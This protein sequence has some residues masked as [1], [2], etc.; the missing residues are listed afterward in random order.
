[1]PEAQLKV[2]LLRYTADPEETVAMAAKLCYSSSDVESLKGKIAVKDQK[3]FVGK[4]IAMGHMSPLEHASFTFAIEGI[5]RACSHQLVRHRI[6]SYSQQSQRYVSE[7]A[8]FDYVI[9]PVIKEDEDLK[10][11]FEDL[12][13]ESQE[14]YNYTV[15]RLREKGIKGESA[16]QDARFILPNAAETKIMVSMNAR[17]LLHFFRV[18]CCNRAQWEIREM[19]VEMLRLVKKTAPLIFSKA[20]PECL[21]S[22]CPEGEYTCGKMKEVREETRK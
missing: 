10:R 18:R 7:E 22:P 2:I 17:E 4:L 14:A 3:A 13:A 8:G 15:G 21:Y 5:S 11:R 9:P 19:A 20:G 6:A 1:M 12:M 16:N